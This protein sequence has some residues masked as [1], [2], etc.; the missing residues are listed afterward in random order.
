[1]QL[2]FIVGGASISLLMLGL[3]YLKHYTYT[4]PLMKSCKWLL[5]KNRRIA[6]G[7]WNP[8]NKKG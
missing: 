2:L 6:S 1:M 8:P 5:E 4:K 7:E 3:I